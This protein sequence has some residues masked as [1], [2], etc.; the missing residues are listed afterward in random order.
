MDFEIL[1]LD[2]TST[3]KEHVVDIFKDV[4]LDFLQFFGGDL[5]YFILDYC[6]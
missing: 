4:Y 5:F 1:V 3:L 2:W 6:I